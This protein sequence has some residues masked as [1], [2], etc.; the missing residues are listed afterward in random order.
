MGGSGGGGG[1]GWMVVVVVCRGQGKVR[2]AGGLL[3]G[4]A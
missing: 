1:D 4:K 2:S 3:K